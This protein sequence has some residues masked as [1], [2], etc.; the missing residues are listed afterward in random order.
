MN[1]RTEINTK[2]SQNQIT[3][4]DQIITIGSCFSENIG[5]Q[6]NKNAFS[7][8]I[9]PFGVLY[10]PFSIKTALEFILTNRNFTE[11][12]LVYHNEQ[13]HSFYHHSSFSCTERTE[14]LSKINESIYFSHDFL[15]NTNY[16]LITF[17]SAYVYEYK[18]NNN[19]VSNCHKIPEKQFNQFLIDLDDIYLS[20]VK[21]I[22]ELKIFNPNLKLIFTVSPIRYLKY[23]NEANS[24]SKSILILLINKLK[25]KFDFI[26]Y[27]PAYEI[28]MDDLRDYRFYNKD[29]I[30]PSEVAIE[31][32]WNKF[33][34][35]FF[36]PNTIKL[37]S[38]V[39]KITQAYN[40]KPFNSNSEAHQKFLKTNLQKIEELEKN[41]PN[42]KLS[43]YKL[44]F[45][46]QLNRI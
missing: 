9:N 10:N 34:D 14:I 41:T 2:K 37:I 11:N 31:Y 33:S 46:K 3:H 15:N 8:L 16:L 42:L 35:T 20:W 27:F 24:V 39:K 32:I 40:H 18:Q 7:S 1:F 43:E 44:L 28:M 25:Q 5:K 12:D 4:N 30:H 36:S 29:M 45:E 17:G 22:N 6:F 21:I 38:E 23:E 26:E 19:I 13:W